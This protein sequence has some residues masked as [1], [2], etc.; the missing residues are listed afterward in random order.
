MNRATKSRLSSRDIFKH[1]TSLVLD[2]LGEVKTRNISIESVEMRNGKAA[3][4]DIILQIGT[5]LICVLWESFANQLKLFMDNMSTS[6]TKSVNV[7]LQ[8]AMISNYRAVLKVSTMKHA[9]R[10]FIRHDIQEVKNFILRCGV[11]TYTCSGIIV[12]FH[13]EES[14][15]Y[16]S[17]GNNRCYKGVPKGSKVGNYC[18][19]CRWIHNYKIFDEGTCGGWRRASILYLF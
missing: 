18:K 12:D 13:P 17:C 14:W 4:C 1:D 6:D 2:V 19:K 11:G 8:F 5:Q 7:V 3:K 16:Q 10:F 9:S 15:Y